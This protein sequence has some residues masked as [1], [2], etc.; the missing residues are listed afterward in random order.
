MSTT[1]LDQPTLVLNRNWQ[2]VH[3]TTVA[4]S[5][6]LLWNDAARVVDAEEYR[7]MSWDD[8]ARYVPAEG[9]PCVRSARLRLKVPEIICLA[10]YDRLPSTAVTFSRR[11]VSRRDHY[12]CQYCGAQPGAESITIDHVL[13]RSQGGASSWTNCA[14]ACTQC[15]ARKGD[16]TPEQAGMK[17]R[18]RP[19]RPE[20]KPFYAALGGRAE[21]WARFLQHEPAHVS[22]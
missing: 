19:V 21:S 4:R 22:A 3:V 17:L 20:W 8:W 1:V 13:P 14:A 9:A 18:R 7:L 16:R 5:L 10:H 12:T 11:N 2:P 6:I 15:N